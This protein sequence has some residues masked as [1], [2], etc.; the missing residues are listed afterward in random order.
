MRKLSLEECKKISFFIL[1]DIADYCEKHDLRYYLSVG[2]LLGAIRHK[3]FIPWD[4]DIDI[5][6]PRPDYD[7]FLNEYQSPLCDIKKPFDKNYSY[8]FAKVYDSRT[9]IIEN[10]IT[11]DEIGL[12]VDVFPLDGLPDNI[13]KQTR[14]CKRIYFWRDL[15][16]HKYSSFD[17]RR[18]KI[19]SF[20][21]PITK[22][23]LK[24]ISYH[25]ICK[26]IDSLSRKYPYDYSDDIGN[27]VWGYKFKNYKRHWMEPAQIGLFE[28]FHFK[29]PN[30][31]DS[32]LRANYGDYMKLPPE[33]QRVTHHE[34]IA[35][36][37]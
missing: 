33:D 30:D 11:K 29:I 32:F 2:T 13:S 3:G 14:H 10:T 18:T 28:G 12:Y 8:P 22:F 7:R 26:I 19:K 25:A 23:L 1:C 17:R 4:D 35:Y 15:I 27:H 6:M 31:Y 21:I 37:K 36:W 16:K 24:P 9:V 5:M 34:F 20:L